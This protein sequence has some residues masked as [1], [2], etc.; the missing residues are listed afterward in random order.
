MGNKCCKTNNERGRPS[1]KH[2]MASG[3]APMGIKDDTSSDG[4]K[5]RKTFAPNMKNFKNI[6]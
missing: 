1:E 6:K 3:A 4:L 5:R 2:K